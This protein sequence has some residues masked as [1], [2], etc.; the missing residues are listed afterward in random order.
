MRILT[1]NIATR[2]NYACAPLRVFASALLLGSVLAG[3]AGSGQAKPGEN[4][5]GRPAKCVSCHASLEAGRDNLR[6]GGDVMELCTSCHNGKLA[7]TEGHPAGL[8]PSN[9]MSQRIP[10]EFP[11]SNGALDCVTCHDM[12][13]HCKSGQ[14]GGASGRYFLRGVRGVANSLSFCFACH[15]REDYEAFNVHDQLEADKMRTET[16]SWCHPVN[17]AA[18]P[19]ITDPAFSRLSGKSRE[20]CDNCHRI[21]RSH[22]VGTP[23][24]GTK[25]SE[26]MTYYIS[27]YEVRDKMRTG[28]PKLMQYVR[29]AKRL[30]RSIPFDEKGAV[31]CH[32]CHNP[33]E[34]G[35]L[36]DSHPRA[37]GAEPKKAE[38]HRFRARKGNVCIVCHDK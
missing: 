6:F 8:Q 9:E 4:P 38:R 22:P 15:A 5:H 29:A 35:V 37:L 31:T 3:R 27:A 7:G 28:L 1:H 26:E 14:E 32:T 23:H 34:K 17:P 18:N 21:E 33:H 11:R 19:K 24:M 10:P 13:G 12:T 16:C 2:S 20:I 25:P 36:P 30:P